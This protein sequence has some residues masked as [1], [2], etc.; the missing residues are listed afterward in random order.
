ML[1]ISFDKSP[2]W[3]S[4]ET[5]ALFRDR[6]KF[7]TSGKKR[8]FMR[9]ALTLVIGVFTAVAAVII[10]YFTGLLVQLKFEACTNLL[11]T[12]GAVVAFVGFVFFNLFFVFCANFVV[13]IEP[14]SAGSGVPEIKTWLNGVAIP[15]L[16]RAQ[17]LL[18]KAIG[19]TFSV[20]GG[21]PCG[22][23]GPMI[24]IGSGLA[25]GLAQGKS[26]TMGFDTSF[27]KFQVS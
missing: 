26:T 18:F 17:T 7:W 20:A 2:V 14:M 11:R 21:L 25:A 10:T 8:G 9:W 13:R 12:G 6:G 23:E 4:Y 1:S 5:A 22:K 27:S 15:R 19:V 24:Q 3:K 16:V